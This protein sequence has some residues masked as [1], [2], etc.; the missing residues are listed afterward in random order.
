MIEPIRQCFLLILL[1]IAKRL[2]CRFGFHCVPEE[3]SGNVLY[4]LWCGKAVDYR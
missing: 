2:G 1:S 3:P 4:C